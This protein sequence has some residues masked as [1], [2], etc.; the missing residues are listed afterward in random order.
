MFNDANYLFH[1]GKITRNYYT[2]VTCYLIGENFRQG[3]ILSGKNL[4]TSEKLVSFPRLIFQIRH[5]SPTNC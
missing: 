4:V 5:F 1:I 2:P 3:K